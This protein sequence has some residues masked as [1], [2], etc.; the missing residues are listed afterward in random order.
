[1]A[2]RK[3]IKEIIIGRE[4]SSEEKK[5][6]VS[7]EKEKTK[8]ENQITKL[9]KFHDHGTADSENAQEIEEFSEQIGIKSKFDEGL[10]EV[11]L[12]IKKLKKGTYG[13]CEQ[14]SKKINPNRML[15]N[16]S[17]SYCIECKNQLKVKQVKK[18][19]KFPWMKR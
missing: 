6:L 2:L 8:L 18:W 1:M 4:L 17:A 5:I 7:L 13:I 12:A 16:K 14:C 19:Y 3:K 9:K 10:S 15:A 11:K